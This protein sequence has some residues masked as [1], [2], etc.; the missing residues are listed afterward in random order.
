L[1]FWY[2][3]TGK[4]KTAVYRHRMTM[5]D[6]TP[7]EVVETG[8]AKDGAAPADGR[9][10]LVLMSHGLGGWSE[11]MSRLAEHL[12]SRG[13]VVAA[14]DHRDAVF[15]SVPAFLLSFANVLIDRPADQRD[16][17]AMLADARFAR[18]VPALAHAD[19][20]NFALIGYSMGGYG[21]LA[22]A[23]ADYSA[24]APPYA[25]LPATSRALVSQDRSRT[26]A[27]V[28]ALVLLAP[29]GGQPDSRVWSDAALGTVSAPLLMIAGDHDDAV[30][31]AQGVRWLFDGLKGSDRRLLVYREAK[32]NVA[33]NASELGDNPA[34][35]AVGYA[36][37]PV[38]RLE[39]INQINQHFI[40]A[41]LDTRLKGEAAKAKYLD[42]PV[43]VAAD[44]TWPVKFGDMT[45]GTFAGDGQPGYWRGFQRGWATGIELHHKPKGQ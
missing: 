24:A 37:D 18:T 1:R 43:P 39:R 31:F 32:H 15:T 12:A 9:Y 28:K 21:A 10:P 38:W 5:P 2:P 22:T 40:T 42:V 3:A 23:G 30:N 17:I 4:G 16:V 7:H 36:R 6:G 35:E 14:I 33:G 25:Q 29:W 27:R 26:A 41:F 45:G 13:Y 19:A 20:A 8:I 34:I 44:G 11:H